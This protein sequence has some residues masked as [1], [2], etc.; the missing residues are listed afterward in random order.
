MGDPGMGWRERYRAEGTEER[1]D[2]VERCLTR[3]GSS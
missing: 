3:P 1:P 2:G